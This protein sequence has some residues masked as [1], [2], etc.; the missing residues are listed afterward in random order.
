LL[1]RCVA[2]RR[3]LEWALLPSVMLAEGREA[4]F[5]RQDP[6]LRVHKPSEL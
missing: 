3:I 5:Y 4:I 6:A 1:S 2:N